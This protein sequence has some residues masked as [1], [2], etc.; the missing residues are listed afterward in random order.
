MPSGVG[1]ADAFPPQ[2][3]IS[4]RPSAFDRLEVHDRAVAVAEITVRMAA[5]SAIVIVIHWVFIVISSTWSFDN[6]PERKFG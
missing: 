3:S 6:P 2:S 4:S 1:G 5:I